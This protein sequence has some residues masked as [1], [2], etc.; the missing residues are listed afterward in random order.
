[1]AKPLFE[2]I[3]RLRPEIGRRDVLVRAIEQLRSSEEYHSTYFATIPRDCAN[4]IFSFVP[5]LRKHHGDNA[6][7]DA[8]RI[9][10][11][12]ISKYGEISNTKRISID[13][14]KLREDHDTETTY[15]S[16]FQ[17]MKLH[18]GQ[19]L[20]LSS[21]QYNIYVGLPK[22]YDVSVFEYEFNRHRDVRHYILPCGL[23]LLCFSR[24]TKI[25]RAVL[26]D[27]LSDVMDGFIDVMFCSLFS[28][29]LLVDDFGCPRNYNVDDYV[30][31]FSQLTGDMI[32][33][34]TR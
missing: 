27:P 21:N 6:F 11:D 15:N 17:Y 9:A 34:V 2:S 22:L 1:M 23:V 4:I 26:L 10:H 19:I 20:M 25:K 29:N 14:A 28:R 12:F 8:K 33:F 3:A 30:Y 32:E 31:Q 24:N 5:D 18:D 13:M 16:I 7:D